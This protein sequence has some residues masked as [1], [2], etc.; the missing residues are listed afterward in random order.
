[1]SQKKFYMHC[2]LEFAGKIHKNVYKR[3]E[4]E[5]EIERRNWRDLTGCEE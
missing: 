3:S 1:M 2:L 5:I 4:I